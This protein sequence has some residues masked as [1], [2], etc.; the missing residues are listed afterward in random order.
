MKI[1]SLNIDKAKKL[2]NI[3]RSQLSKRQEQ[4][5]KNLKND[6][7]EKGILG[8]GPGNQQLLELYERHLSELA[9]AILNCYLDAVEKGKFIEEKIFKNI[10]QNIISAIENQSSAY[11]SLLKGEMARAG[12]PKGAIE[13]TLSGFKVRSNMIKQYC[14]D[15]L[16]VE[17]MERN[18]SLLPQSDKEKP[19]QQ[20][21]IT[22]NYDNPIDIFISHSSRDIS[23]VEKL[24]DL[25][26]N[27]LNLSSPKIRCTSV[28]GYKLPIGADTD[29]QLRREVHDAKLLIGLITKSSMQS[30]YV[31]FELGA[32]WGTGQPMF[33]LLAYRTDSDILDGPLKGINY[34]CC[35]NSAQLHQLIEEIASQLNVHVEKA[36]SFQNKVD[37]IVKLSRKEQEQYHE[38]LKKQAQ[39]TDYTNDDVF[40]EDGMYWRAKDNKKEGPFCQ[41]CWDKD[42]KLIRLYSDQVDIGETYPVFI[43][44][45]RNCKSNYDAQ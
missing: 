20:K 36:A 31:L 40:F 19:D 29:E 12:L 34:L 26:R 4:E 14:K 28:D 5:K 22:P 44:K 16:A 30:A 25:L 37:E 24:I 11:Q 41:L 10:T 42:K 27:A 1:A 21:S 7:L 9:E 13:S 23:F 39:K 35:D 32:R 2:I 45:C 18:E 15:K 8:Q 6:L 38:T 17:I 3:R 43:W 33:P